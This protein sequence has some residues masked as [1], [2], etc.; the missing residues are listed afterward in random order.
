MYKLYNALMLTD[1]VA[2]VPLPDVVE[3]FFRRHQSLDKQEHFRRHKQE[4]KT[5][6]A[7]P[8]LCF[9]LPAVCFHACLAGSPPWDCCN[10]TGGCSAVR[11]RQ[12]ALVVKQ[13]LV[14]ER[15]AAVVQD[16]AVRAAGM[17]AAFCERIGLPALDLLVSKFQ[18]RV[19]HG[20]KDDLI[21][22]TNIRGV[23]GYTARLL[24]SAGLQTV[25]DVARAA[26]EDVHAALIK[27]K[28]PHEVKGD[29][30]QARRLHSNAIKVWRVRPHVAPS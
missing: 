25:E 16:Q 7:R 17:I 19:L 2:E 29:W 24:Y 20:I 6:Q 1:I 13:R 30:Q 4:V 21:D 15:C 23:K 11:A 9:A 27:G 12:Q 26:V 8:A 28:Q 10:W 14:G 22:L 5:L 18:G 3:K